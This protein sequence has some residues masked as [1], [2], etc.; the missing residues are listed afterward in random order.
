MVQILPSHVTGCLLQLT[1]TSTASRQ[2]H[3][4]VV[5]IPLNFIL[6]FLFVHLYTEYQFRILHHVGIYGTAKRFLQLA[7]HNT[8]ML[9]L[10]FVDV[11]IHTTCQWHI[12]LLSV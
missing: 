1:G 5:L 9:E 6:E 8:L 7:V 4:R 12:P 3:H 2:A 11:A 10:I